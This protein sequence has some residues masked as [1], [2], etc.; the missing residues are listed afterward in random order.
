M[1]VIV[2][3]WQRTADSEH[4]VSTVAERRAFDKIEETGKPG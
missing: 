1:G 3:G 4:D 2:K